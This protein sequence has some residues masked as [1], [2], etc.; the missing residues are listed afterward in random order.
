MFMDPSAF[1]KQFIDPGQFMD[2]QNMGKQFFEQLEKVFIQKM[3][4]MINN[5]S[6]L[7]N[8]S[9]GVETGLDGKKKSDDVMREYLKKMNI[10]TREDTSKI[11]QYLQKIETKVLDLEDKIED[12]SDELKN[13][14]IGKEKERKK[15]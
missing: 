4:E 1:S 9:K 14:K 11:L 15:K 12:L 3:N 13:L 5:P 7:A 6:F 10:P 8:I 2:P